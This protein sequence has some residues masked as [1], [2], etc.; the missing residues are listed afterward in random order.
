MAEDTVQPLNLASHKKESDHRGSKFSSQLG[1]SFSGSAHPS[2]K[3][4][5]HKVPQIKCEKHELSS[6]NLGLI[7]R[8]FEKNAEKHV[9]LTLGKFMTVTHTV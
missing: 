9:F 8:N 2:E 7:I 5:Q 4:G 6:E 1:S 3:Y